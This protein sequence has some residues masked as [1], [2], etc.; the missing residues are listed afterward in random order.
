MKYLMYGGIAIGVLVLLGIGAF[1][2][3]GMQ[4]KNG[5]APGLIEGQLTAC[6]DSPNCVSSETDT[7]YEKRVDPLP[8]STW[9]ALPAALEDMGGSVTVQEDGYIAAEFTSAIFGF[10]DDVEFRRTDAAVQV[11]S[12]S[13]VGHSDAGVN[14]DRV[15]A[16]REALGG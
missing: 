13:R 2:Y 4:S 6:P 16:L 14:A 1:F 9:D 10:V 7:P 8:L 11:R 15:P 3:L 5:T 12:A